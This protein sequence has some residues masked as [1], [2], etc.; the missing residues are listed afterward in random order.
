MSAATWIPTAHNVQLNFGVFCLSTLRDWGIFSG[1]EILT[2]YTEYYWRNKKYFWD[3]VCLPAHYMK[4]VPF[5]SA[6]GL[7]FQSSQFYRYFPH[8]T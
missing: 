6:R 2:L 4:H 3:P 7:N 1:K 5:K 8:P